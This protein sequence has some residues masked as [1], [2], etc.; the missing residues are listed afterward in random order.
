MKIVINRS[1]GGFSLSDYAVK[2]LGL[3][4]PY[5]DIDRQDTRLIRLVQIS[6]K[7]TG[8]C[9]SR[10]CIVDI[11]DEATDWEIN[12]YDGAEYIVYVLDGKLH[13]F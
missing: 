6:A 5:D 3:K 9:H 1:F 7:A 13:H 12:D 8:G 10:L 4:S 2:E 11:P